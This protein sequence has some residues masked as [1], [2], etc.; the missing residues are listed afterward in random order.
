[1]SLGGDQGLGDFCSA[2]A[3]NQ[4]FRTRFLEARDRQQSAEAVARESR[5]T[6][7]TLA[8]LAVLVSGLTNGGDGTHNWQAEWAFHLA[9]RPEPRR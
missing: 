5:R 8:A 1:M 3:A 2:M 4:E 9:E 6:L 7:G